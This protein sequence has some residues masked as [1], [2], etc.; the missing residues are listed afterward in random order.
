M[1]EQQLKAGDVVQLKSGGPRMTI[2]WIEDDKAYCD[3]FDK[4]KQEGSKFS[5][6]QLEK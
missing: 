3:W 1:S 6:D 2:R 5:I 4:N